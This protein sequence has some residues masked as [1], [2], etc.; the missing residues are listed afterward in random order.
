MK[1]KYKRAGTT[2]ERQDYRKGGQVSKD[3][4]RQKFYGGGYS[5][6][7]MSM[8]QQMAQAYSSDPLNLNISP[9]KIQQNLQAR[10]ETNGINRRTK[11]S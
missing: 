7:G 3:G 9:E 5:E 10:G 1:K 8:N 4:P 2:S 11:S 6:Y